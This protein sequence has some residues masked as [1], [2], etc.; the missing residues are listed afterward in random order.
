MV[1]FVSESQI[2]RKKNYNEEHFE[3]SIESK[4]IVHDFLPLLECVTNDEKKRDRDR[5]WIKMNQHIKT[6]QYT[7]QMLLND[8]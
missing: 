3:L 2:T 7:T 6:H 8:L 4:S 1:N 5:E